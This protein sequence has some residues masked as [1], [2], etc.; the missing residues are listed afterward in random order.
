[1]LLQTAKL[2]ESKQKPKSDHMAFV[3]FGTQYEIPPTPFFN[4]GIEKRPL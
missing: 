2:R 4:G 1:M 3:Y